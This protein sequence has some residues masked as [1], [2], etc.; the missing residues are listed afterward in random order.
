MAPRQLPLGP[1]SG[2][3]KENF[4]QLEHLLRSI[5][6]VAAIPTN[7]QANFL[8]FCLRDAALRYFQTLHV[9]TGNDSDFSIAAPQNHFCNPQLQELH[10]LKPENL[11]SD[12]KIDI[13]EN[14]LVYLQTKAFKIYPDPHPPAVAPIDPH[15][16]D[17]GIEQTR[18]ERQLSIQN[19]CKMDDSIRT[20][21]SEM[22]P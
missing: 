20:R 6:T 10:V 16:R 18:V 13:P 22:E 17:A 9:A 15:A 4:R 19:L 14:F 2:S 21:F 5:L 1:Y 11:K 12:S 3:E 8:Q 7:Q